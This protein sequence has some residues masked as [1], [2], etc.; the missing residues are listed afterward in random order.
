MTNTLAMYMSHINKISQKLLLMILSL[1][2]CP[3]R[4][5]IV[6]WSSLEQVIATGPTPANITSSALGMEQDALFQGQSESTS[7][8]FPLL[9]RELKSAPQRG[10][11]RMIG[12]AQILIKPLCT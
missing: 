8:K 7:M 9:A 5:S 12:W 3:I 4:N 2:I 1:C 10:T 6:S 11:K